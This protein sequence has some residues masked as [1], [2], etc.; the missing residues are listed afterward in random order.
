MFFEG[1]FTF[2]NFLMDA[3]AIFAFVVWFWLGVIVAVGGA[4]FAIWPTPEGRRRRVSD[5]YGARLARELNR[6]R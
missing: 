3:L 2:S 6:A 5:V 4:L 1:G